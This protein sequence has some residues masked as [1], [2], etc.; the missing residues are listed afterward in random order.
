MMLFAVD[1]STVSAVVGVDVVVVAVY[2]VVA[3]LLLSE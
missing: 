1:T 2:V 3:L